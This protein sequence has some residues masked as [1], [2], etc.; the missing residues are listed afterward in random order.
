MIQNNRIYDR[1]KVIVEVIKEHELKECCFR[2]FQSD[3]GKMYYPTYKTVLEILKKAYRKNNIFVAKLDN[4]MLGFIWFSM[5]G[6]FSKFPYLNM[7]FVFPEFRESGIGRCLLS[8]FENMVCKENKIPK[9]KIFLLV[10]S[11]NDMALK[12]YSNSGYREL[13]T[14]EG[15]FRK[16]ID[17]I[18]MIKEIINNK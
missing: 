18:L 4:A 17:E 8:F 15:L 1:S 14:F 3:F 16:K 13:Y 6:V 11:S 12:L 5:D 7:L 9:I 2:L 10:K